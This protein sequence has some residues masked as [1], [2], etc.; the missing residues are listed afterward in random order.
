MGKRN[1]ASRKF[2]NL[3]NEKLETKEYFIDEYAPMQVAANDPWS[4]ENV[5]N[6]FENYRKNPLKYIEELSKKQK[7]Y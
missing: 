5:S 4:K 1:G 7:S 6:N 2:T 3:G